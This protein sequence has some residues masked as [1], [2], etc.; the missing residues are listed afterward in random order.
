MKNLE[1]L[2]IHQLVVTIKGSAFY[3]EAQNKAKSYLNGL[4]QECEQIA[5]KEKEQIIFGQIGVLDEL[6]KKMCEMDGALLIKKSNE[7]KAKLK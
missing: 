1:E 7:L 4:L 6:S 5:K 2:P 3:C